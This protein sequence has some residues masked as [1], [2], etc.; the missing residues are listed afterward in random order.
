M[1]DNLGE[2]YKFIAKYISRAVGRTDE[3]ME[4]NLSYAFIVRD[5]FISYISD[6]TNGIKD[7]VKLYTLN[8]FYYYETKFS[9]FTDNGGADHDF[10]EY[11]DDAIDKEKFSVTYEK[12]FDNMLSQ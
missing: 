11:F 1:A 4:N 10:P 3:I 5:E 7:N 12:D 6:M 2:A 9:E 8:R